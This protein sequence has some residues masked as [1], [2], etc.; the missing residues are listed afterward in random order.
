MRDEEIEPAIVVIIEP[1]GGHGPALV[2]GG[3]ARSRGHVLEA[4]VAAVAIEGAAIEARDKEVDT[5]IVVEVAGGH[6][7]RIAFARQAGRLRHVG[8]GAIAIIA[9]EA[10]VVFGSRLLPFRQGCPIDEEDIRTAV[11]VVIERGNACDH[12]LWLVAMSGG[13]IAQDEIESGSGG[14]FLKLNA[15][16]EYE[17]HAHLLTGV[18]YAQGAG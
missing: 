5:A 8:E 12:D 10:I 9:V 7:H 16:A 1:T 18:R 4:A 11:V 15:R 13:S 17:V 2:R 14:G 3:K 6:S